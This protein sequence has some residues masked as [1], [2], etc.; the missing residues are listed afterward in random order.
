MISCPVL[1]KKYKTIVD[2]NCGIC[3]LKRDVRTCR[4]YYIGVQQNPVCLRNY[5]I[6]FCTFC[7]G[8]PKDLRIKYQKVNILTNIRIN[9]LAGQDLHFLSSD[10]P[11]L[12]D[13]GQNLV[14][15]I[16]DYTYW[17]ASSLIM[18]YWPVQYLDIGLSNIKILD[19]TENNVLIAVHY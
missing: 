3:C 15:V 6:A 11:F 2:G 4:K 7:T 5:W 9:A 14:Y 19:Y 13:F 8:L 18:W 1:C 10:G 17:I 12:H 16:I